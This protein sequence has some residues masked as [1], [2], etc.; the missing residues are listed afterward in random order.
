MSTINNRSFSTPRNV[1]LK[2]Q[3]ATRGGV[4]LFEG[5]NPSSPVASLD[6]GLYVN[7]SNQ[8]IYSSQGTTSVL[9]AAGGA[10]S[11]DVSYDNGRTITVDAGEIV[12]AD[13]TSAR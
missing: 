11:L 12:L 1:N 8:L 4:L 13:S 9:G 7:T 10:V 5:T 6:N 3:G 2:G